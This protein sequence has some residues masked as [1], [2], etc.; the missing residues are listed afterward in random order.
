MECQ[1]RGTAYRQTWKSIAHLARKEF[2]YTAGG[3]RSPGCPR[4]RKQKKRHTFVDSEMQSEEDEVVFH[5]EPLNH[6]L[7]EL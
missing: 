3:E 5:E 4:I 6:E 7:N 2:A 1:G